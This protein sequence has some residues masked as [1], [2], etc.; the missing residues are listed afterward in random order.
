MRLGL[1]EDLLQGSAPA[2]VSDRRQRRGERCRAGAGALEHLEGSSP[3]SPTR[4]EGAQ[5]PGLT[6][7]PV[8]SK[9]RDLRFLL[10]ASNDSSRFLPRL[11]FWPRSQG[12]GSSPRCSTT[13]DGAS[14]VLL[15]RLSSLVAC[16]SVGLGGRL[17]A[18][19]P[20][21]RESSASLSECRDRLLR[22]MEGASRWRP[23]VPR[24]LERLPAAFTEMHL[25]PVRISFFSAAKQ[26]EHPAWDQGHIFL[27]L[28]HLQHPSSAKA[29]VNTSHNAC[30]QPQHAP[31]N[32][33]HLRDLGT[34]LSLTFIC[35]LGVVKLTP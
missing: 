12:P 21:D 27:S 35:N 24:A 26:R 18:S 25:V 4:K 11:F 14:P 34:C 31:L 7:C 33:C 10:F 15:D 13:W 32:A 22:S 19:R 9:D 1:R 16:C 6:P 30:F 8:T 17:Q 3:Q 23:S 2:T 5:I 29:E 20:G 28:L